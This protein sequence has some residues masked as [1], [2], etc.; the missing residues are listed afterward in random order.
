LAIY[1]R[2]RPALFINLQLLLH[3]TVIFPL[4]DGA[5]VEP[6]LTPCKFL[7]QSDSL[8]ITPAVARQS[9]F[10]P[11]TYALTFR[12]RGIHCDRPI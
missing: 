4:Q 1:S 3:R 5:N 7:T 9:T 6:R 2:R 8:Y 12:Q 10:L 11:L